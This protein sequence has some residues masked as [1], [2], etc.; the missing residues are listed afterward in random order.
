M[1]HQ[2]VKPIKTRQKKLVLSKIATVFVVVVAVFLLSLTVVD[3]T[4]RAHQDKVSTT[5]SVSKVEDF[6][7][8]QKDTTSITTELANVTVQG[9]NWSLTGYNLSYSNQKER[10][11]AAASELEQAQRASLVL[12]QS[13]SA[14][15]VSAASQGSPANAPGRAAPEAPGNKYARGTCTWYAFNRRAALGRPIGSFWGNG[16][17]WHIAAARDGYGVDHMPEVGAVFE[18]SGHVAVVEAVG[19]NN[20]VYISE[21]N[22]GWVPFRYNE[23]W[24]S[25]AS[26]YWY[27]H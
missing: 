23:R 19:E 3:A 4:I 6:D 9:N 8:L 24:V 13:A 16:G 5:G 20:T 18:Q 25:N 26:G 14:S 22:F 10:A 11:A 15:L 17:S 1:N 7:V 2:L 21:M 12:S 27:I